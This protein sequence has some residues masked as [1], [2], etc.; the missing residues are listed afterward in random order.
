MIIFLL[1]VYT[2]RQT[3]RQ[4]HRHTD[5]DEY[6]I[7]A[8]C[9]QNITKSIMHNNIHKLHFCL[10]KE[11]TGRIST[12]YQVSKLRYRAHAPVIETSNCFII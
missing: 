11:H 3:H 6:S 10:E 1:I 7:V 4:T 2:D 12:S 5:G 9:K 8:V